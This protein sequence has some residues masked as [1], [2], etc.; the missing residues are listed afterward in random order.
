MGVDKSLAFL[1]SYFH[2]YSTNKR[3]FLGWV[4]EVGTNKKCVE[5]RGNS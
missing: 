3:I 4:K 1:T 5:L 2:I